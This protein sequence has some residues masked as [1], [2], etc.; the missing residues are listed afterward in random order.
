MLITVR[1]VDLNCDELAEPS[2]GRIVVNDNYFNSHVTYECDPGYYMF[3]PKERI[4]QGDSS[5]S[6]NPPECKAKR[7]CFRSVCVPV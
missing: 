3:G 1:I 2:N 4:C 7:M 5:W 6:E